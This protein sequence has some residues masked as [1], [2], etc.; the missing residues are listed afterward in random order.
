VL[1]NID[2][3]ANP[4][5]GLVML[6]SIQEKLNKARVTAGEF[7]EVPPICLEIKEGDL[8]SEIGTLGNVSL[9]IGKAK[10]GKTFFISMALA[11]AEI[12]GEYLNDKIKVNLPEDKKVV[13]YF[14]TEQAKFHVQRVVKRICALSKVD[15]PVNLITYFLRKYSP[16]ERMELIEH[17]IENTENLGFVVIDGIRDL[18]T[19]INDE[20]QSTYIAAKLLKWTEEQNIHIATVLHTN[21]GDNNARGHLG[22]ELTNKSE[23]VVSIGKSADDKELIIVSPEYCRNREFTPFGF[24][25]DDYGVPYI[26]DTPMLPT[27]E[28]KKKS[29]TPVE[30]SPEVHGLALDAVF[31]IKDSL[32]YSEIVNQVND[33]FTRY[34]IKF[35]EN[36]AKTFVTFY[37]NEYYIEAYEPPK[38]Y[39]QYRRLKKKMVQIVPPEPPSRFNMQI[40][41]FDTE[42]PP[43]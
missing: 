26:A 6:S 16:S 35:G 23:T 9:F 27:D 25:I 10:Q 19:S 2:P 22:A 12:S 15:E 4:P 17:A 31:K 34:G 30:I 36:K 42:E 13:I 41:H 32:K 18:V 24:K 14:D 8:T 43:F 3:K 39:T 7:I 40:N 1:V 20:D 21:K 38:G 33:Y 11:A 37:Q 28:T 5:E 29:I